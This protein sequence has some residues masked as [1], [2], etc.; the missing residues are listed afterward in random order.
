LIKLV[1]PPVQDDFTDR[2]FS[3][4]KRETEEKYLLAVKIEHHD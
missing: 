4:K 2:Y 1:E 3:G